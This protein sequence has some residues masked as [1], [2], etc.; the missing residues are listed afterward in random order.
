MARFQGEPVESGTVKPRFGGQDASP[1]PQ[2][3]APRRNWYDPVRAALQGVTLG[4]SDELGAGAAAIPASIVTRR[5]LFDVYDEMHQSLGDERKAYEENYPGEALAAEIAGALPAGVAAGG[6]LLASKALQ[7]LP[8]SLKLLTAGGTEGGFY[9]LASADP[10]ERLQGA[11]VGGSVGAVGAPVVYAGGNVANALARPVARKARD[12]LLGSPAR[13]A[14]R[15]LTSILA[16]EGVDNLDQLAAQG[17]K[18]P[19]TLADVSE[20]AKHTAAGIAADIENPE[21]AKLSREF[22]G[23]RNRELTSRMLVS[24]DEAL[25]LPIGSSAKEVVQGIAK[26]KGELASKLYEEAAKVPYRPSKY[27]QTILGEK[28]PKDVKQ[29]LGVAAERVNTARAAGDEMTHFA[30]IDELKKAMDDKIMVYMRSG[31]KNAARNLIRVKKRIVD[32]ID[33]QNPAYKQARDT[34]SAHSALEDA[35]ERG[36]AIFKEDI[37]YLDDYLATLSESE[38]VMHLYGVKQA[39]R[40]KLM[41]GREGTMT[42]NRI[43]SQANL[44]RLRKAFPTDSAF[45]NFKKALDEEAMAFE[46]YRL[47]SQGSKTGM[48]QAAQRNLGK[49]SGIIHGTDVAGV[50]AQ[51]INRLFSGGLSR[52]AKEELG[53]MILTPLSDL[54]EDFV[55]KMSKDVVKRVKPDNRVAVTQWFDEIMNKQPKA[56]APAVSGSAAPLA[57]SGRE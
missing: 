13:D 30:L 34:F 39:I 35:A 3:E 31:E 55:K 46:T 9:G 56:L 2:G 44:E 23:R 6:K 32:D 54:P 10:G 41:A 21:I 40:D 26:Q 52:E 33:S 25:G 12:I 49:D 42:L 43:S 48:V 28:G 17:G 51:G 15:E 53:R 7:K 22:L 5:N 8:T 57:G 37:D 29:A 4:F 38:R 36:K 27:V 14:R 20:G 50:A 45:N 11:A 1:P 19:R 47:I 18:L 24:A 16:R